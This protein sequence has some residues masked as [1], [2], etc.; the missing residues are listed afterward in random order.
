MITIPLGAIYLIQVFLPVM[1]SYS[2]DYYTL[3]A[4]S[5]FPPPSPDGI[6]QRI[7]QIYIYTSRD[8]PS[9]GAVQPKLDPK[10]NTRDTSFQH[11]HQKIPAVVTNVKLPRNPTLAFEHRRDVFVKDH[12]ASK[13]IIE[14]P[15]GLVPNRYFFSL[16]RLRVLK[17][18]AS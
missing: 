7:S 8:V 11:K 14:L 5:R 10:C 9:Q 3:I 12:V 17:F 13:F 6:S 18:A 2:F 16:A 15:F 4:A 1:T